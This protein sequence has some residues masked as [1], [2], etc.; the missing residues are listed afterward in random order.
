M[1]YCIDVPNFG[2][3]SDPRKFAEFA[4]QVEDAGWDGISVWDHILVSD[5]MQVADPWILLAAAAM[6]TKRIRLMTMV[7]P[8][9]RRHPWKLARECVSLD[10]LSEGRLTL[11]VGLG[12]PTDPEFTRFGGETDVRVRAD[13]LDEGLDILTGLWTGEPYE[14]HGD[15]YDLEAVTFLPTPLQQPRIPIW[16]AAMWPKKRPVR[17]A[18]RWD[19]IA[20]I[21]FDPETQ[22][23]GAPSPE[24]IGAIAAYAA[25]HRDTDAPF[26]LAVSGTHQPGE[27]ISE[28]L[29]ELEQAGATWWRDG[30]IPWLGTPHEEWMA[31]I[32][33]GPPGS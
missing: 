28:W 2:D 12:W 20:P 14:F 8:L 21:I 25:A 11:G 22:E 26:D 4:K 31:D 18:A 6:T 16:V 7:T 17:R 30:W 15:H 5:D 13:M 27:D 23:F 9:P 10:L 33:Q 3:W 29:E 19:G 1:K 24:N 32:L